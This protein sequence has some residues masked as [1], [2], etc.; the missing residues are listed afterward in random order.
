MATFQRGREP[1]TIRWIDTSQRETGSTSLFAGVEPG[2]GDESSFRQ[3]RSRSLETG[4]PFAISVRGDLVFETATRKLHQ[5]FNWDWIEWIPAYTWFERWRPWAEAGF[6]FAWGR[7]HRTFTQGFQQRLS[8][9][10]N[11]RVALPNVYTKVLPT[12][13][14]VVEGYALAV[15][16]SLATAMY[17]ASRHTEFHARYGADEVDWSTK[18]GIWREGKTAMALSSPTKDMTALWKP[19]WSDNDWIEAHRAYL[20]RLLDNGLKIT[21]SDRPCHDTYPDGANC[22]W[23]WMT[24]ELAQRAGLLGERK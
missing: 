2:D 8:A 12:S 20:T 22:P 24:A 1:V 18:S 6:Q 13:P 19:S 9:E 11:K 16:P 10:I 17:A 21:T 7:E 15:V 5:A 23:Q 3:A 14:K 4:L